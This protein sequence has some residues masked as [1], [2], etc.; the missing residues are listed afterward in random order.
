MIFFLFFFVHKYDQTQKFL[1]IVATLYS[2]QPWL[3]NVS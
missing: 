2:Q 1:Y 3:K